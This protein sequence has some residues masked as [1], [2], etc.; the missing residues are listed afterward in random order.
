MSK[1]TYAVSIVKNPSSMPMMRYVTMFKSW[2]RLMFTIHPL[3]SIPPIYRSSVIVVT[4]RLMIDGVAVGLV[5]RD[6]S[7]WCGAV[8]VLGREPM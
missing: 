4:I 3:R 8:H 5:V 2:M 7:M 6:I 1:E